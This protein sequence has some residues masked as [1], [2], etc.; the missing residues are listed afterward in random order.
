MRI[1]LAFFGLPRCSTV[2]F[3]SI[4]QNLLAPESEADPADE[5]DIRRDLRAA[6]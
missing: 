5:Q 1:A 3:P 4:A 2:A 6:G